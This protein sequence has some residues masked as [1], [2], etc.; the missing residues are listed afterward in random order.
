VSTGEP[1]GSGNER[2]DPFEDENLVLMRWKQRRT[3]HF[4]PSR[5]LGRAH[6]ASQG[7]ELPAEHD[8]RAVEWEIRTEANRLRGEIGPALFVVE[9]QARGHQLDAFLKANSD[10]TRKPFA[11]YLRVE[12]DLST[13]EATAY[14]HPMREFE[15]KARER[16]IPRPPDTDL[17]RDVKFFALAVLLAWADLLADDDYQE[18]GLRSADRSP[19]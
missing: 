10:R 15:A 18:P 5:V 17:D 3:L 9:E 6:E 11:E 12:L 2:Q 8:R 19:G 4:L 16:G 1:I 14:R 13:T 7:A